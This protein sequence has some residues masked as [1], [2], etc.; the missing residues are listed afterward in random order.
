[1]LREGVPNLANRVI[2]QKNLMIGRLSTTPPPKF[3]P[4]NLKYL[5][6]LKEL[7]DKFRIPYTAINVVSD[8]DQPP[9][10]ET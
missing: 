3:T 1:M 7:L 4:R 9:K 6:S 2:F 8:S 5:F 10:D